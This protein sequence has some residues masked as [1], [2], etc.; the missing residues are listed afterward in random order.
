M[1][2]GFTTQMYD[3]V[4]VPAAAA[5]DEA[6]VA[7]QQDDDEEQTVIVG[8][9]PARLPIGMDIVARPFGEPV[10]LTIAAAYERATQHREPPPMFGPL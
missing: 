4:A 3:R 10:I 6:T 9:V 8:P 2:V 7:A 5:Q 1:P